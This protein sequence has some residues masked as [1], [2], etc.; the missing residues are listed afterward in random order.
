MYYIGLPSSKISELHSC[1]WR[2]E[3]LPKLPKN[4]ST[5]IGPLGV[6]ILCYYLPNFS[7]KNNSKTSNGKTKIPK[8]VKTKKLKFLS[9]HKF[10]LID[11]FAYI[12]HLI[13]HNCL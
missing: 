13:P 3:S 5:D 10:E 2:R 11:I 6:N 9:Y 1:F 12:T 7:I 4:P 8:F